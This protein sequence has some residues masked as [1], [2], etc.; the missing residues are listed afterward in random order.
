MKLPYKF[1]KYQLIR[2]I[3]QGG[4][5]EIY[6]AKYFGESGFVKDVAVKRIL[7]VW[8]DNKDFVTMLC[9]EAKALVRL[10]HQNIVQI[11]ELGK[12]SDTF[13]ISMEY[14]EGI[15]LRQLFKKMA[16]AEKNLQLPVKFVCFIIEEMLKG[17]DCAHTRRGKSG[18]SLCIIHR[19]ISPQNILVSFNGEV[20]IADFGIAKGKHRSFETV[21]AQVKGKYAYMSPEQAAGKEIDTRCDLYSVGVILY[22]LVARKRLY[23]APND[24]MTIEDV[25][26]SVL[27]PEWEKDV[28]MGMR[29]IIRK[30]LK[31]NIEERYQTAADFLQ[32]INKFVSAN[33]LVTH[34]IELS[35][36]LRS[37]LQE[38]YQL[39]FD[40]DDVAGG[41][42]DESCRPPTRI[43]S[44]ISN[45]YEKGKKLGRK[46]SVILA[47]W[48]IVMVLAGMSAWG[49]F[50]NGP[51]EPNQIN[52]TNPTVS[53]DVVIKSDAPKL[54]DLPN[55]SGQ[56][57]AP[58]S[59]VQSAF[60]AV[61]VQ[62]RPWGYVYIPGY[63]SREETPIRNV[64][65]KPG[66]YVV[67]VN[68]EPED[69]WLQQKITLAQSSKIACVADFA[70]KKSMTCKT[71]P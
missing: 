55:V 32:D 67:K 64:R 12:D 45:T 14:V 53:P 26:N 28:P 62:A 69:K 70:S 56:S 61:S 22:E 5:A 7:P 33:K 15:D 10:Q 1:G 3:A 36:Y 16:D 9:D 11:Y 66:E 19:D 30:A 2:K 41:P 24:L 58:E 68:Y 49:Y 40:G 65:L 25:K 44:V 34:G 39:Y 71:V 51:V 47:S 57:I 23:N 48:V 52:V 27:P 37:S 60:S 29:P 63:V 43:L 38:E 31:K 13:Y 46:G 35:S 4:M 17:L 54:P 50:K 6:K 18:E 21:A 8:S 42:V 20:K 59:P